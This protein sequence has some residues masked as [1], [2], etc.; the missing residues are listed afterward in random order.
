MRF[1][2]KIKVSSDFFK[3]FAIRNEKEKINYHTMVELK[4][5]RVAESSEN[6]Y[7][8]H[9]RLLQSA[10][11]IFKVCDKR[12][13]KTNVSSVWKWMSPF[14][15]IRRALRHQK[16]SLENLVHVYMAYVCVFGMTVIKSIKC[17]NLPLTARDNHS[18]V[19]S[20]WLLKIVLGWRHYIQVSP[21]TAKN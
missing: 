9:F 18:V 19:N 7:Q 6:Q 5:K 10:F 20:T 21:L 12:K 11:F 4:W 14:G 8:S 2:Q 15:A 13:K 3:S 17:I 16:K 1:V